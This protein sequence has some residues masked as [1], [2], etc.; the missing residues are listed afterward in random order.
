VYLLKKT[1]FVLVCAVIAAMIA[2]P[3]MAEYVPVN[4]ESFYMQ[5]GQLNGPDAGFHRYVSCVSDLG[6]SPQ[7]LRS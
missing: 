4:W 6:G 7:S 5:N 3:A 2:A 1:A